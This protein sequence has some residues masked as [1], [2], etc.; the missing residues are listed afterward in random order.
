M[1]PLSLIATDTRHKTW[2]RSASEKLSQ[3]SREA[4]LQQAKKNEGSCTSVLGCSSAH[5]PVTQVRLG[6]LMR[7]WGGHAHPQHVSHRI[8]DSPWRPASPNGSRLQRHGYL[9]LFWD[10]LPGPRSG[11]PRAKLSAFEVALV[12]GTA[13]INNNQSALI[14]H[15]LHYLPLPSRTGLY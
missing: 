8:T 5:W 10:H 1:V 2:L 7:V 9:C 13:V 11:T 12:L 6:L 14:A 15:V 4:R 3:F